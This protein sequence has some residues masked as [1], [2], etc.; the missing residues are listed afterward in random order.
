MNPNSMNP[1]DLL[2]SIGLIVA[3]VATVSFVIS[4]IRAKAREHAAR[5]NFE[6]ISDAL[7]EAQDSRN[8]VLIRL[9]DRQISDIGSKIEQ[10]IVN[11]AFGAIQVAKDKRKG[12]KKK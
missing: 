2:I 1:G 4:E 12:E 10:Q 5:Q 7:L 3:L 9:L 6:A 8:K 11:R